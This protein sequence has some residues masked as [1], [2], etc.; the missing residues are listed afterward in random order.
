MTLRDPKNLQLETQKAW[1][2]Y[3][4]FPAEFNLNRPVTRREFA[5]LANRFLN[6]FARKVDLSGKLVN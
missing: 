5:V 6:P 2:S 4:K 1:K 3:Y